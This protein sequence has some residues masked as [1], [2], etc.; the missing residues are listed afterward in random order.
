MNTRFHSNGQAQNNR[1]TFI[2][3]ENT[4]GSGSDSVVRELRST[5]IELGGML[6]GGVLISGKRK[7]KT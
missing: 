5:V 1:G 2:C 6:S 3:G 7:L 4:N